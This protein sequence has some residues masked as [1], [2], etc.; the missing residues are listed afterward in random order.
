[1]PAKFIPQ[2]VADRLKRY[3]KESETGPEQRPFSDQIQ[4]GQDYGG[5]ALDCEP[6]SLKR[7]WRGVVMP[8]PSQGFEGF[9]QE[10]R[11]FSGGR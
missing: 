7:N 8:C 11:Q 5:N 4:R 2:N 1:M 10:Y 3:V 9:G 6:V